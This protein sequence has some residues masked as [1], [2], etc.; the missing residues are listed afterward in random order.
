MLLAVTP[1]QSGHGR[2][3]LCE[4]NTRFQSSDATHKADAAHEAIFG[5][6]GRFEHFVGE[7]L[8]VPA[9]PRDRQIWQDAHDSS[10]HAV[11]R[12]NLAQHPRIGIETFAPETFC[13]HYDVAFCVFLRQKI[14]SKNRMDPEQLEIVCRYITSEELGRLAHSG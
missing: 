7:N 12:N 4:S 13:H 5:N 2:P 10:G 11:E 1:L 14:A 8:S 9:K 3:R 6:V